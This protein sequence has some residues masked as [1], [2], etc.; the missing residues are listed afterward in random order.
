MN[1]LGIKV[2]LWDFDG[3]FY[4]LNDTI[5]QDM[6]EAQ[7]RVIMDHTGWTHEKS[8]EEHAKLYKKVYQSGT[9]TSAT[10][11]GITVA[12]AVLETEKYYDRCKYVIFDEKLVSMFQKL[13]RFR[14]L[15]FVNGKQSQ[16]EKAIEK[17]GLPLSTFEKWITPEMTG[18]VKP[19]PRHTQAALDYTG[20]PPDQHLIVGDREQVDLVAGHELG[21]K[22]CLVNVV[23]LSDIADVILPQVYDVVTILNI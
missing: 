4:R 19:D 3:T 2:I 22:T 12:Q 13:T 7:F 6:Y 15:M 11:A 10:L 17:L 8:V 14:H 21:M 20:L 5:W 9:E 1:L 23:A 16:E 18:T